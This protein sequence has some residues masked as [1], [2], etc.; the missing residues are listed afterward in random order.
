MGIYKV[1]THSE[2]WAE[3]KSSIILYHVLESF[4]FSVQLSLALREVLYIAFTGVK[5]QTSCAHSTT[6][7]SRVRDS[8]ILTLLGT[9]SSWCSTV[10]P[11]IRSRHCSPI[12]QRETWGH[13]YTLFLHYW[14][15]TKAVCS[16]DLPSLRKEVQRTHQLSDLALISVSLGGQRGDLTDGYPQIDDLK[17]K[18]VKQQRRWR[19]LHL[20]FVFICF[21]V[22]FFPD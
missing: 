8:L 22:G 21:V 20:H 10:F 12:T 9:P 1:H 19:K 5:R 18:E 14:W 6:P 16:T 3:E 15:R 7:L 17:Q 11:H 4:L 2:E 13:K